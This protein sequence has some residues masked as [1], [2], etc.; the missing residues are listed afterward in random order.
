MLLAP[1]LQAHGVDMPTVP[2]P[3]SLAVQGPLAPDPAVPDLRFRDIFRTPVGP[4]GLVP[5]ER[6][7]ALA[8]Q[9]VRMVGYAAR[10]R[11]APPGMMIFSPLPVSLGGE[12]ESFADDLPVTAVHVHLSGPAAQRVLPAFSGLI[13]L[14]GRLQLGR[15][16]ESDG[17]QSHVRLLLDEPTS[18]A[19]VQAQHPFGGVVLVPAPPLVSKMEI[20]RERT[21]DPF[22]GPPA[23]RRVLP[24]GWQRDGR[25][26]GVA[27]HAAE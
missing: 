12:D 14:T 6:L 16:A 13:V 19:L 22:I 11:D 21:S 10:W 1:G 8:G 24:D 27:A 17:R 2:V 4:A 3:P 25:A 26:H 23:A 20:A 9:R 18:N 7:L 5:G 15:V